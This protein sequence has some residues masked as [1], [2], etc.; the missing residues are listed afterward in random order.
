MIDPAISAGLERI[1]IRERDLAHAYAPGFEPEATDVSGPRTTLVSTDPLATVPPEGAYFVAGA[2]G[3]SVAYTRDGRFTVR[4]GE[5]RAGDGRPALG[6]RAGH[7]NALATLR[8]D[9]Y[10]AALGRASAPRVEADGTFAYARATIDPRTGER[11]VERVTVGRV[12][13]ARFPAGSQPVRDGASYVRAPAGVAA[14]VGVPADAAF[15]ALTTHARD[16]GRLDVVAGVEK[17]NEAYRAFDALR[18]AN[19]AR[20]TVEKTAMDL[21]K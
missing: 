13:L 10:D 21:L 8:I 19:R 3:G 20:G 5:L 7:P 14:H 2:N 1:D 6:F 16:L 18:A 11:R 12:A 4:D 17:L 15:A 9:P